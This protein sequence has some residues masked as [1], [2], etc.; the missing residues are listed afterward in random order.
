[1]ARIRT[2]KP[3]FW[4]SPDVGDV[5]RDARLTFIGLFNEA[6]DQGRLEAVPAQLRASLFPY[7]D[8]VTTE[9]VCGWLNELARQGLIRFYASGRR[10]YLHITGWAD[11]QKISN[12]SQP[13]CPDPDDCRELDAITP[14]IQRDLGRSSIETPATLTTPSVDPP[15][16]VDRP[17]APERRSVGP[18]ERRSV[19]PSSSATSGD[20]ATDELDA[21]EP[22]PVEESF[23]Q[24]WRIYPDRNGRKVGRGN[25]LIEWRKL[26]LDQRRRA[27]IGARN[28]AASD[29]LPK[30]AERFLRRAKGGK[31]DFPFDD[32]QQPPT[33]GGR[34]PPIEACPD[35]QAPRDR[36][37][38]EACELVKAGKL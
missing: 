9:M 8:D 3:E 16:S 10:A 22:D 25:A 12:P 11:H 15:E 5:S 18:S 2:V 35:C 14:T 32:W 37:D 19:G 36:H 1:M 33:T 6:D 31:G 29:Q 30:D 26:T 17:S 27:Y 34:P 24:F 13:R 28:L 7:D 21:D 23:E 20:V 38:D 4:S